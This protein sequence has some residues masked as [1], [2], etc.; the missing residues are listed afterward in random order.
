MEILLLHWARF[1]C[2]DGTSKGSS[3]DAIL[4]PSD[5]LKVS[6]ALC[7]GLLVV[8]SATCIFSGRGE[9][10]DQRVIYFRPTC[11]ARVEGCLVAISNNIRIKPKDS[12]VIL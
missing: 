8:R 7:V 1:L 4:Y 10:A 5:R 9:A 3:Y 12:S 6:S 11:N 2:F